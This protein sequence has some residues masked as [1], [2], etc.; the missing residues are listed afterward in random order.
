MPRGAGGVQFQLE[1]PVG[2]SLESLADATIRLLQM[3]HWFDSILVIDDSAASDVLS[4]RMSLMLQKHKKGSKSMKLPDAE[5]NRTAA[6]HFASESQRFSLK[7]IKISASLTEK[8]VKTNFDLF[9][10]L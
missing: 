6:A 5:S 3:Q 10:A 1:T 4:F 9:I 7:L 2:P 8:E